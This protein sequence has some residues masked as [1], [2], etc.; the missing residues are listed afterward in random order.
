MRKKAKRIAILGAT[1]HIAK[2]IIFHFLE[3]DDF[4][5]DLYAR[6]VSKVTSFLDS[7]NIKA[8]E[9]CTVHQGYSTLNDYAYDVVINCVGVGTENR[10]KGNYSLYFTVTEE[11]D[12]LVI[13][14]L[15]TKNRHTL[16]ISISSGAVYGRGHSLP[17]K[18][19]TINQIS[20]N[21]VATQDY[22]SIA[23]L[24][25]E[26]KHRSLNKYNIVDLRLFSYFSRFADLADEYFL[27]EV[28]RCIKNDKVLFTDS[29]NMVRDYVNPKDFFVLIH[30]CMNLGKI[31]GAF[32]V[33]SSKAAQKSEILD[34]FST[35][36][37]LKY[38]VR[39]SSMTSSP[40]GCKNVYCS[41]YRKFEV[42]GFEPV[43]SSMDT[44]KSESEFILQSM[45]A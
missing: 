12:N 22:Y 35:K 4:H 39:D 8:V 15:R 11:Y 30:K 34:F 44:I 41:N 26:A 6:S 10:L 18:E 2:G 42:I 37:D 29:I 19:D 25:A 9:T 45:P 14:Y 33:C 38:E 31:N 32:D 1:S 7:I 3:K 21:H 17:V 28:I 23:R 24:N 13:N 27:N 40:T 20:V 16:Y 5:L 43:F 36:Y